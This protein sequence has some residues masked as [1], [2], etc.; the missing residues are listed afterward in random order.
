VCAL[1]ADIVAIA[2]DFSATLRAVL[3]S[4]Y[5]IAADPGELF[6][7]FRSSAPALPRAPPLYS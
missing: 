7:A 4:R 6:P 5:E 3:D 2:P 1:R